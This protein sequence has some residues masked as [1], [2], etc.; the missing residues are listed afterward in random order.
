VTNKLQRLNL[1]DKVRDRWF[2]EWGAGTCMKALKTRFHIKFDDG[3]FRVFDN[4]HLQFL[5]LIEADQ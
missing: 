3:E 5:D 4:A 1:S 2:Q